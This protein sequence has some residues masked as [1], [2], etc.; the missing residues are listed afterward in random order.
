[1]FSD[2]QKFELEV[3]SSPR[4]T[5]GTMPQKQ[6]RD[7]AGLLSAIEVPVQDNPIRKLM[8]DFLHPSEMT[9]EE[10]MDELA[11]ILA[12]GFLRLQS[13]INSGPKNDPKIKSRKSFLTKR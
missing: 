9:P 1:M 13:G 10:R 5:G 11:G 8:L 12:M 2:F 3:F 6:N 7:G 4:V